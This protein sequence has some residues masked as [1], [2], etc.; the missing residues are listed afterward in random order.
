MSDKQQPREKQSKR[1][2]RKEQRL[3]QER[4]QR[5]I[6]IGIIAVI[7][8]VLVAFLV[9][10]TIQRIANPAGNFVRVTP[11]SFPS[12]KG[13][14]LG[15]PNAKVKIEIFEDFQCKYCKQYTQ[16][17]EP[18]VIS[19]LVAPGKASYIFYNFPI[20]DADPTFNDS[21]QAA[22]A[23]ECAADQNKFW[24]LHQL[25]YANS[26]ETAGEFSNDRLT[27]FAKTVGLDMNQFN[28]CFAANKHKDIID[29]NK[30]LGTKMGVT[31][32]P[33]VFVNGQAVA[34]GTTPTFQQIQQAVQAASSGG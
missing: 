24:E 2:M 25:L 6:T 31:G 17:T 23:A 8:L 7:A 20:L 29:Q 16:E 26:T 9:V 4:Q 21:H 33:S 5:L 19:Q 28:T 10:P 22:N 30:A 1:Q 27:A 11:M 18:Q 12:P 15:D 13:T 3:K 32:T 34:P 14:T